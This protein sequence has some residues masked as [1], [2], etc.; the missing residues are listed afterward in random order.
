MKGPAFQPIWASHTLRRA[1]FDHCVWG[2]PNACDAVL[3][4]G[5]DGRRS[6][7]TAIELADRMRRSAG[8]K[9]PQTAKTRRIERVDQKSRQYSDFLLRPGVGARWSSDLLRIKAATTAAVG[10]SPAATRFNT[11]STT[12]AGVDGA[13]IWCAAVKGS[14]ST[15][16]RP[17]FV[18]SFAKFI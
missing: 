6:F 12:L 2:P 3:A 11:S 18:P 5:F 8:K 9:R 17:C 13:A 15:C 4:Q 14:F 7:Q 16:S 1:A 10:K